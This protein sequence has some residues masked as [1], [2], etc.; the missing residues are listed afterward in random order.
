MGDDSRPGATGSPSSTFVAFE[1]FR[2]VT[3]IEVQDGLTHYR[4]PADSRRPDLGLAELFQTLGEHGASVCLVKLHGDTWHF[5]SLSPSDTMVGPVLATLGVKAH[6]ETD[7]AVVATYAA[8]MRSMPGVMA[9]IV[10]AL[11]DAGVEVLEVDDSYNSVISVV[12]AR[13]AQTAKQAIVERLSLPSDDELR[14]AHRVRRARAAEA[15]RRIRDKPVVVMK[16]GGTSVHT[17]ERR[18]QAASHVIAAHG[19]GELP[20]VVVSAMGRRGEPYATDTLIGLLSDI[21]ES[22]EPR[23]MD[24]LMACGEIISTV[25]LA[26]IIRKMSGLDAVPFTGGQAG[27]VTDHAY[28]RARI[29]RIDP[30]SLSACLEQGQIPVVAGFQGVTDVASH[31]LHGSITTLGRGGSDTTAAALGAALQ[32]QEVRIF[33]DVP[34]VLTA[35][36]KS[37]PEARTLP[38]IT[39]EEICEMAHQGAKVIHPRAVEIAIDYHTPLRVLATEG[40]AEGT[41]IVAH[42]DATVEPKHGVVGIAQSGEVRPV[43]MLIPD[44]ADKL[45]LE[46]EIYRLVGAAD[47]S[48]HFVSADPNTVFFVVPTELVDAARE[49]LVGQVLRAEGEDGEAREYIIRPDQTSTPE[50]DPRPIQ[51]DIGPECVIVSAIGRG[52]RVIP[53]VMGRVARALQEAAVP[54]EQ[55]AGSNFSISCLIDRQHRETA[56]RHLHQAFGLA[57]E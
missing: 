26:H 31:Q 20:V 14:Q 23:S 54:I 45:R 7:C 49:A 25:V 33:T 15:A 21:D 47:V 13:K 24:L 36:P 40:H 34:G 11:Q 27:I 28:G 42:E 29:T 8:D 56:I 51:L 1:S 41:R 43:R 30:T 5:S 44:P 50:A 17:D 37:V 18:R 52:Q 19:A 55:V 6:V 22:I 53:G 39:Q 48:V 10:Q 35:D 57:D 16:F 38:S 3:S 32:A 9:Q 4:L 12:R 2:G 46:P